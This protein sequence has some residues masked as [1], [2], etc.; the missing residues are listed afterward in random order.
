VVW[1]GHSSGCGH[2]APASLPLEETNA[3]SPLL[4]LR[5]PK[6]PEYVCV[7]SGGVARMQRCLGHE[8]VLQMAAS[9]NRMRSTNPCYPEER[10]ADIDRVATLSTCMTA[11]E[12]TKGIRERLGPMTREIAISL[13]SLHNH[14]DRHP[15]VKHSTKPCA[16]DKCVLL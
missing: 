7:P 11:G 13:L 16:K 14:F 9:E 8:W 6:T 5:Q 3:A 15:L 4:E 12:F 1:A 10:L 2:D